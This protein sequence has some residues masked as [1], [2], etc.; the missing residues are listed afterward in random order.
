MGILITAAQLKDLRSAF[1]EALALLEDGEVATV[2]KGH[3]GIVLTLGTVVTKEI[4]QVIEPR[5]DRQDQE[6]ADRSAANRKKEL[7]RT[8]ISQGRD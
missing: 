5:M 3:A 7:R 1:E 4:L 2:S 8:W 6:R